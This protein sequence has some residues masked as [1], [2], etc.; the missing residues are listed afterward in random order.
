MKRTSGLNGYVNKQN[1]R[2]WF[3]AN[4]KVYVETPLH[5]EKLTVSYALWAVDPHQK[6][7]RGVFVR[8]ES[9]Y[10]R[11]GSSRVGRIVVVRTI[12]VM[13][14]IFK[15]NTLQKNNYPTVAQWLGNRED[16]LTRD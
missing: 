4:P 5:P 9:G 6:F 1:C 11:K 2:I 14:W 16:N 13:Q 8:S 3:E 12:G 7:K 10:R 15:S